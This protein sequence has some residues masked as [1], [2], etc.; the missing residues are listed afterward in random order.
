MP[1]FKKFSRYLLIGLSAMVLLAGGQQMISGD[2]LR[3]GPDAVLAEEDNCLDP[4]SFGCPEPGGVGEGAPTPV[5]P[6]PAAS[7]PAPQCTEVRQYNECISCNTSR[8]ISQ[9]SCGNFKRLVESQ[10]DA[11]CASWCP[12]PPPLPPPAPAPAAVCNFSGCGSNGCA[13]DQRFVTGNKC[14]TDFNSWFKG[15]GCYHDNSCQPNPAPVPAPIPAPVPGCT[16]D[17]S[18]SVQMP[19]SCGQTNTGVDNCGNVCIK[20]SAVCQAQGGTI[21]TNNNTNNNSQSQ[22]VNVTQ[23]VTGNVGVAAQPQVAGVT[24]TTLPKTGLPLLAWSALAFIPAGFKMGRFNK[25][26]KDLEDDPNYIWEDRQ[27][28]AGA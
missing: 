20:K 28:K 19:S 6:V 26:K 3:K 14:W 4:D 2:A 27:F 24:V 21:V 23:Q 16:P 8:R 1:F 7:A 18:C 9:D 22:S 17:G 13:A 11:G 10:P 15:D 12:A 5:Q 25:V